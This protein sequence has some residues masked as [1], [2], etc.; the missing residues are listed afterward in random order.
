MPGRRERIGVAMALLVANAVLL[1][2][3]LT[4]RRQVAD[5]GEKTCEALAAS[6]STAHESVVVAG[7]PKDIDGVFFF[8]NGLRE[9]VQ[10]QAM[11]RRADVL[12]IGDAEFVWDPATRTV[13]RATRRSTTP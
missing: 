4:V 3:N 1:R 11:D 5:L 13:R 10:D 6:V 2:M 8:G 9:C 7:I 12:S